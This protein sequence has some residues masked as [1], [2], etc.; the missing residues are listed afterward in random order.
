MF[1]A[2]LLL[3]ASHAYLPPL[4]E[5]CHA[6]GSNAEE[7]HHYLLSFKVHLHRVENETP[8]TNEANALLIIDPDVAWI[9]S[10]MWVFQQMQ[11]I[12]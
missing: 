2:V 8:I 12:G 6:A 3:P 10:S 9:L 11:A 1:D 5:L 7:K 4:P